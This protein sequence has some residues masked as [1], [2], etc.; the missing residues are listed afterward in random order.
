MPALPDGDPAPPD[1]ALP[2]GLD[3]DRPLRGHCTCR[4][5]PWCGYCDFNTYTAMTSSV[6]STSPGTCKLS[7]GRWTSYTAVGEPARW[8]RCSSAVEPRRCWTRRPGDAAEWHSGGG[9]ASRTAP[10]S[11]WGTW[12]TRRPDAWLTRGVNAWSLGCRARTRLRCTRPAAVHT[13]RG[14][15]GG[16]D[17]G[18][19]AGFEHVA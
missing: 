19:A 5:A 11:R 6:G 2:D 8:R 16:G 12:T 1:G 17:G 7:C 9:S 10:R 15:R 18:R 3:W 4:S 13:P 14:G